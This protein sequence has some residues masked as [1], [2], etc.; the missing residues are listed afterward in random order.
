MAATSVLTT[1]DLQCII[2]LI[3]WGLRAT[4]LQQVVGD[5][6][7]KDALNKLIMEYNPAVKK[8]GRTQSKPLLESYS[9]RMMTTWIC[10]QYIHV[11]SQA[12]EAP[13]H[14]VLAYLYEVAY[15]A[16]R[17][18]NLQTTFR[19]DEVYATMIA[20]NNGILRIVSC[21]GDASSA[22]PGNEFEFAIDREEPLF[23]CCPWCAK[24][25]LDAKDAQASTASTTEA[26]DTHRKYKTAN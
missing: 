24:K 10:R 7:H 11:L 6:M 25:R 18:Y 17:T 9:K 22:H 21:P 4:N 20:Y 16:S 13:L 1:D 15:K 19:I 14:R 3:E 26:A 12:P 8:Q 2:K 5:L 23:G